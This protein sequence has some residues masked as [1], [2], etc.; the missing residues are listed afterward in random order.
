MAVS[1]FD[2]PFELRE[3][4]Y[5]HLF[6]HQQTVYMYPG[7]RRGLSMI[8]S[9]LREAVVPGINFL[10]TCHFVYHEVRV[11]LQQQ[12]QFK[13]ME[14]KAFG[15]KLY[16]VKAEEL[17]TIL[18]DTSCIR[19]AWT[20][21]NV[22]QWFKEYMLDEALEDSTGL[23]EGKIISRSMRDEFREQNRRIAEQVNQRTLAIEV[24]K[25]ERRMRRKAYDKYL[26][27]SRALRN[28]DAG[29][30]ESVVEKDGSTDMTLWTAKIERVMRSPCI[31]LFWS[32]GHNMVC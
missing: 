28:W 32:T 10:R 19:D 9:K 20:R 8:D 15:R 14:G 18:E 29:S 27:Q 26:S 2:L 21:P 23:R 31:T 3:I 7:R 30:N 25:R 5:R 24:K 11:I 6:P 13:W 22:P 4:I 16:A 12:Y 17:D 1:F